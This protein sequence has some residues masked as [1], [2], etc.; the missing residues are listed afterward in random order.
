[1]IS[2]LRPLSYAVIAALGLGAC[3]LKDAANALNN[4]RLV[5]ISGTASKGLV[6][7]GRVTA[8]PIIDGAID[9]ANPLGSQLTDEDGQYTI[10]ISNYSGPVALILTPAGKSSKTK[11][12]VPT[13]CAQSTQ[14]YAF[15]QFMP[16]NF[17]MNAV[18]PNVS[19]GTV[20]ASV[21]PLT[22]MAA[23]FAKS[24]GYTSESITVANKKAATM[25]GLS[26]ILTIKPVDITD[27]IALGSASTSLD[28]LKYGYLAAAIAKIAQ[29]DHAGD[30]SAALR[31]L[32]LSYTFN[33]GELQNND[34][35]NSI[36]VVTLAELT[37]AAQAIIAA[38]TGVSGGIF[39]LAKRDIE[40]LQPAADTSTSD[41]T[42]TITN[43]ATSVDSSDIIAAKA[44]VT[45]LR[46]WAQT[47][48][49]E[50]EDQL[51]PNYAPN[52]NAS[53]TL[54]VSFAKKVQTSIDHG[55]EDFSRL[56]SGLS[57]AV[58]AA[59][60]IYY[61]I[62]IGAL[63][64]GTHSM[65]AAGYNVP[66]SVV[67]NGTS[68]SVIDATISGTTV[69]F[70]ATAPAVTGD[71]FAIEI[72]SG[73]AENAGV[74]LLVAA[75]SHATL[76]LDKS[77]TN[78][79]S[80]YNAIGNTINPKRLDFS[81]EATLQQKATILVTDP[82]AF[83]GKSSYIV[84]FK[85][86]A[87][88]FGI[89]NGTTIPF[90]TPETITSSGTFR[91]QSGD[92]ITAESTVH[93][94]N[95]TTFIPFEQS[96]APA[97]GSIWTDAGSYAFSTDGTTLTVDFADG[98]ARI[99][100]FNNTTHRVALRT[101]FRDGYEYSR[102]F[103][104]Y[105]QYT[106]LANFLETDYRSERSRV[107][108]A[109]RGSYSVS[110]PNTWD[111]SGGKISGE[112]VQQDI[113]YETATNWADVD[114]SLSYSAKFVGLPEAK[115]TLTADRTGWRSAQG[116]A[117]VS[118]RNVTMAL[119]ADYEKADALTSAIFNSALV[120]DVAGTGRL[121]IHPDFQN[122]TLT[123]SVNVDGNVAGTLEGDLKNSNGKW[124]IKYTNGDFESFAF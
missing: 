119:N 114:S 15:G 2:A 72:N 29:Q 85:N 115:V 89:G 118:Y 108:V 71:V 66:G 95:A 81:L 49:K 105:P 120:V 61:R 117:T 14:S 44:V 45:E 106:S 92:K 88:I 74:S 60:E 83:T 9:Q 99:Y 123:G 23:G 70:T 80:G 42:T 111:T 35:S 124:F 40:S 6:V 100:S 107:W 10:T 90:P 27:T 25:L 79:Y 46:T 13:G 112:L 26:D 52:P 96:T 65:A 47:L 64:D 30:I 110:L 122:G 5:Q 58:E 86:V 93:V 28:S 97:V 12:D 4:D 69:S 103:V 18:I 53:S 31:S 104:G 73:S 78:L 121:E 54:T 33:G 68:I 63:A 82:I 1:M 48:N 98:G 20:S 113:S 87:D 17:A 62:K 19:E 3:N 38:E 51:N 57:I 24:Q 8:Y 11:C 75:G 102:D 76:T 55:Q 7:G 94:T 56:V 37:S 32:A 34:A 116:R 59:S 91:T 101:R 43:P 36:E 41:P 50:F 39:E 77:L 84:H 22:H 21:T 67:V 109:H 16:F